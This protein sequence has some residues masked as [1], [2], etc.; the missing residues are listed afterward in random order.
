MK[1]SLRAAAA[2]AALALSAPA[3]AQ[4]QTAQ[5]AHPRVGLG[6]SMNS[7]LLGPVVTLGAADF[8]PPSNLYVP[9]YLS[10][11]FRL[12]P[13]I[14]WLS[15]HDDGSDT[16]DS[17]FALGVGALFVKP[18]AAATNLY[19]GARLVSTWLKDE[20]RAGTFVERLTRRNT[21]LAGVFGGEWLPS[22]WFSIGIEAQLEFTAIGDPKLRTAAGTATGQG[23]S[24]KATEGLLFMRVY[25]I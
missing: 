2:V 10:P 23:G 3:L 5:G 6:V 18:V 11:S 8:A 22:A 9:I 13:Q 20:Q 12:E 16:T 7:S 15:V 25:F 24:A 21:T 17:A 1:I 19:G 14:G 4:Q